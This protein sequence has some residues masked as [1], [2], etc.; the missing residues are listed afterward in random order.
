[1]ITATVTAIAQTPSAPKLIINTDCTKQWYIPVYTIICWYLGN[2]K[3]CVMPVNVKDWSDNPSE[4]IPNVHN[5][6]GVTVLHTVGLTW[7]LHTFA[8]KWKHCVGMQDG[9][10]AHAHLLVVHLCSAHTWEFEH[11]Y[12]FHLHPFLLPEI[13]KVRL[14]VH[15]SLLTKSQDSQDNATDLWAATY[16]SSIYFNITGKNTWTPPNWYVYLPIKITKKLN[17]Q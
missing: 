10:E 6:L 9:V 11:A 5:H 12:R 17:K 16:F 3:Q 8:A 4:F 1:V 7:K 2:T 13:T 15:N 14:H